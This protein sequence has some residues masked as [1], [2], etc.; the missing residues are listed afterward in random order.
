MP[1][2]TKV[3]LPF[4]SPL[5]YPFRISLPPSFSLSFSH[6]PCRVTAFVP[7]PCNCRVRLIYSRTP[8]SFTPW[9][10]LSFCLI[11]IFPFLY[12]APPF[13]FFVR[14]NHFSSLFFYSPDAIIRSHRTLCPPTPS[15]CPPH[16]IP[17]FLATCPPSLSYLLNNTRTIIFIFLPLRLFFG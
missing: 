15:R 5:V 16:T 7:W 10:P 17:A 3:R 8:P 13:S 6:S 1:P 11:I 12:C 4:C 9:R 2:F 14:P